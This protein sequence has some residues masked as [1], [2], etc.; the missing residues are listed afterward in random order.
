VP[1][2]Q[3]QL[4]DQVRER[5]EQKGFR[6]AIG[7]DHR[8]YTRLMGTIPATELS[9]LPEDLRWQESGWLTPSA[10]AEQAPSPLKN[11]WPLL[12]IEVIPEPEELALARES[13]AAESVEGEQLQSKIERRLSAAASGDGRV[14]IEVILG[15]TPDS[16]DESWRRPLEQASA[17]LVEGRL[18]PLV[19]LN[20]RAGQIQALARLPQVITVRLPR[21]ATSPSPS[22]S[23]LQGEKGAV[24]GQAPA[25]DHAKALASRGRGV[26]VALISDDF[27]NYEQYLGKGLPSGTRYADMT[28]ERNADILP[29]KFSGSP[30]AI[31]YGTE[32]ALALVS[33]A[34]DAELTLIRVDRSA[35][36][37]LQAV[38]EYIAGEPVRSFC[39][40]DRRQELADAE[41]RIE[42]AREKLLQERKT[43]LDNFSQDAKG[44]KLRQD[45]ARKQEELDKQEKDAQGRRQRF[46]KL[47]DD[48]HKLKGIQVVSNT[49]VW[50]DGY[51]VGGS[52]P[53]SR[54]F[55]DRPFRGALWFQAAGDTRGQSW[56]GLFRDADGNG[57]MEF[58]PLDMPPRPGKWT[59]ELN[60]LG[61]RGTGKELSAELPRC[62]LRLSIQWREPHDPTV[63]EARED[64]Y[65]TPLANLRLV[66]LRQRDPSGKKVPVDDLEVVARSAGLP[67]RLDNGR[68]SSTY[69]QTLE[70]AVEQPG[71][72][73]LRVEGQVPP[74]QRP[75]TEASLPS[76]Q[77]TWE[78]RPRIFVRSV[79]SQ[80][81]S[82]GRPVFSDY[83][84]DTGNLGMPA[85]AHGVI[86]VGA[87]DR[88][89]R[90][91]SYSVSGSAS[92]QELHPKP[93]VLCPHTSG[94]ADRSA[95][96]GTG[97]AA[98]VAAGIVACQ[99]ADGTSLASLF[100]RLHARPGR[101]LR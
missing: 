92:G 39:L 95:A 98:S 97:Y 84:T 56:S 8:G 87:V 37:Q 42:L 72:Y 58:A 50:A 96:A 43:V 65:R 16:E 4:A 55:D 10:P 57:V 90:V 24:R 83:S 63:S 46:L 40:R 19:T 7:Y 69:E 31:G 38:A 91:E 62:R 80:E 17:G 9:S 20:A 81:A 78:L 52:S 70:L 18:G 22:V 61:W 51:P 34:P 88:A 49:L 76:L 74:G 28:A 71:R 13:S 44:I 14:R 67:L 27:R 25:L 5:L 82:E 54:Y 59:P 75:A 66:V 3:R 2:E 68:F 47:L 6:E 77:A 94:V 53:L 1:R 79:E 60:F 12:V 100:E 93:D 86:T 35:P 33:A 36:H 73:A 15:P 89:G 85:D 21:P 41:E 45:Y 32:C 101:V 26:R 29:D 30:E 11:S 99:I 23:P 64:L 48:V